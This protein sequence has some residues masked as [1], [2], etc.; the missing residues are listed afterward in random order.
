MGA[1]IVYICVDDQLDMVLALADGVRRDA[2]A[3]VSGVRAWGRGAD[4]HMLTGD[5]PGPAAG[6]S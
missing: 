5:A 4:V 1:T 3:F 6:K 2:K